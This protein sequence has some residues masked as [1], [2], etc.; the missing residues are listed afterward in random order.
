M[1]KLGAVLNKA[2]YPRGRH[3]QVQI[4]AGKGQFQ[5]GKQGVVKPGT[6]LQAHRLPAAYHHP[7][8]HGPPVVGLGQLHQFHPQARH[9]RFQGIDEGI[10][11]PGRELLKYLP[12]TK[13]GFLT[14]PFF[15][16]KLHCLIENITGPTPFC[17][18]PHNNIVKSIKNLTVLYRNAGLTESG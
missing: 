3:L 7:D 12:A 1:D 6:A 4:P 9:H 2:V 17:Q 14:E 11:S 8:P 10:G 18:G 16:M 5:P 15:L 13:K